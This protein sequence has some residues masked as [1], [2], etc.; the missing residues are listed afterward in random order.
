MVSLLPGR[1][2]RR[3]RALAGLSFAAVAATSAASAGRGEN[4]GNG[5]TLRKGESARH[6]ALTN[7][8]RP[9][10]RPTRTGRVAI[11]DD[12][13][14]DAD[15]EEDVG[16]V[17]GKGE[18]Y[19]IYRTRTM[20]NEN[21]LSIGGPSQYIVNGFNVPA[22]RFPWFAAA[23]NAEI[24]FGGCAGSLIAQDWLLTAGHCVANGYNGASPPTVH[25]Y[26]VGYMGA[27]CL[28]D[29]N[30]CG[31][32]YEDVQAD[33]VRVHPDYDWWSNSIFP[34]MALVKLAFPVTS[35]DPVDIDTGTYVRW[36]GDEANL[37]GQT[38]TV[39]GAGWTVGK[40]RDSFP[41]YLQQVDVPYVPRSQCAAAY[42]D[43]PNAAHWQTELCAGAQARDSC[44]GDSGGPLVIKEGFGSD[45]KYVLVGTVS[46]GTPDCDGT[47]PGVYASVGSEI[48]WIR[49]QV[50]DGIRDPSWCPGVN[51]EEDVRT[52]ALTR[53]EQ[54]C[55]DE[56][57][58]EYR[59]RGKRNGRPAIFK[60]C[61]WL[62][63]RAA[64]TRERICK[65]RRVARRTCTKTCAEECTDFFRNKRK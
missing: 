24:K 32:N 43:S 19:D 59:H 64:R 37:Y 48:D 4:E 7:L 61:E 22:N 16:E 15:D 25:H 17:G 27:Q 45:A 31:Q 65:R 52:S 51:N 44:N 1:Q 39:I 50:C 11:V 63:S 47:P 18:N 26:E 46:Y 21:Y 8:F 20:S 5:G 12:D 58:L 14:V 2:R 36:R 49:S 34:D 54:L 33:Y 55:Q 9:P 57:V 3:P 13:N 56:S 29:Q 35:I 60:Y 28:N 30:N 62:G 23:M 42:N 40:N 53:E 38:F 10:E 41:Q 6:V